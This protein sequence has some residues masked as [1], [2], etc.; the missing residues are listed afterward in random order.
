MNGID[1]VKVGHAQDEAARTGCTVIL[2]EAG[3]VGAVDV[4]GG[5]PATRETDL[6]R[7]ENTVDAVNAVVL[8]GGSAFG[9]DAAGGVMR[10]LE[11]RGCGF[12]AGV[13]RV[14]IVCGASLFDLGV[15]RADVRPDAA[16]GYAACEAAVPLEEAADGAIGAGTGAT[17]GKL[18]GPERMMPSGVGIASLGAG[19][20]VVAAISAVNAVG[21]VV[22]ADGAPLA[23]VR[24]A[25]GSRVL[26]PDEALDE[27]A[28]LLVETGEPPEAANPV[29][30]TTIT[31][32][33]TNARL[34]KAQATKVASM[35][36]DGYARAINPVHTTMDGDTVFVLAT[37]E[38]EISVDPVGILAADAVAI[39]IRRAVAR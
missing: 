25:D 22:D 31:C 15:G 2:C 16:M 7:P 39:A 20:L 33:V 34:T 27:L 38:V 37:G 1:G 30:N 10:W 24:S 6:L 36:H 19:G 4:R 14:P 3:A 35:A 21:T 18:A 5:G 26:A 9:L 13:C 17:V 32:V 8:S 23:G 28:S 11:E 29:A 12:D